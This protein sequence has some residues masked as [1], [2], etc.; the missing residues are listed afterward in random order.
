[1]RIEWAEDIAHW[2]EKE[3][4]S[5][6]N[7]FDRF[8]LMFD[9]G[10]IET[11]WSQ[12]IVSWY[13]WE[14]FRDYPDAKISI[15]HHLWDDFD[16]PGLELKI[17]NR[18]KEAV[19]DAYPDEDIEN[20]QAT[21]YRGNNRLHNAFTTEGEAYLD[22]VDALTLLDI[23][24]RPEI[25]NALAEMEPSPAGVNRA[26]GVISR[27]IATDP[28]LRGNSMAL[29]CHIGQT[30]MA[31]FHQVLGKRGL[32][33]EVDQTIFPNVVNAGF[34]EG[35]HRASFFAMI[36]R[37]ASKAL[38]ATDDPVKQTEYYNR[39][40][41][42]FTYV[43]KEIWKGDCGSTE[44]IPW[45][46][47]K[48]ELDN[49]LPGK[50]YLTD[51][52]ELKAIKAG[53]T[54]LVG[55]TIQLRNVASCWHPDDG[56]VCTTCMGQLSRSV[57][58]G[59]NLGHAATVTQN[60]KVSQDVI[61]TKHLLR[62]AESE[63]FEIDPFYKDY[64]VNA[65]DISELMLSENI[66]NNHVEIEID[67][68]YLPRLSDIHAMTDFRPQDLMRI[69]G[70]EDV[71]IIVHQGDEKG[72]IKEELIATS[73]SSYKP[74]LTAAFVQHMKDYGFQNFGRKIRVDLKNW[75]S[76]ESILKFPERHSS[77]L[78]MMMELKS[79]IFMSSK[80]SKERLRYDLTD[81][82]ILAMALKDISE[83]TN[84]KFSVN[85]AI[86]EIVLYAMMSRDP[87]NGDFRLPKKG[88]GRYFATKSDIMSGRSL[89][90]KCAYEKQYQNML[91]P[92]SYDPIKENH[93]FDH[94]LLDVE[95]E[96]QKRRF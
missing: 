54:F 42:L 14:V 65:S 66:W 19:I 80:E 32:C 31:Q 21:I 68:A 81:P 55:K 40:L 64:M 56:V 43:V 77:T 7:D 84:R 83:M 17:L 23:Y 16:S 48:N 29:A 62:S 9:D 28:F 69:S 26:Y 38:Q 87:K 88:T 91:S 51:K 71:T 76:S 8:R 25:Q 15:R 46:V 94:L 70:V 75:D 67:M 47:K 30:K 63:G 93:P 33:S 22:T 45:T 1:M 89:S 13:F 10:E 74:Y 36:S 58:K 61:S 20:I 53:D 3:L 52:G 79:N 4:W 35:I 12:T 41:Q 37:D 59:T 2:T 78:E 95:S 49:I 11:D 92:G 18:M 27:V 72:T 73:H 90:V 44:T 96:M 60:E 39:E 5:K 34:F 85:L 82:D 6:E 86:V 24:D 50:I 57:Q